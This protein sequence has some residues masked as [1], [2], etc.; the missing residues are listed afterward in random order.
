M[1]VAIGRVAGVQSVGE[2]SFVM[3]L[4]VLFTFLA[5]LGIP[6]LL[7]RELARCREDNQA[8]ARMVGNAMSVC[9]LVGPV[10]ILAMAAIVRLTAASRSIPNSMSRSRFVS[11]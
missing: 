2:Y 5:H 11:Y 6:E 9:S 1:T 8:V 7:V 3:T 10:T 4:A